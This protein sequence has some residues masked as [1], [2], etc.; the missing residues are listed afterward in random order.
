MSRSESDGV[1]TGAGKATRSKPI[2]ES[3]RERRLADLDLDEHL[4]DPAIKQRYVSAMFDVVAQRYDRFTRMFSYG[5]DAGWKRR[6][7]E[8]LSGRTDIAVAVDLACGSGDLAFGVA[9][10]VPAARV[11][12]FDVSRPMVRL[13][14]HRDTQRS[15]HVGA[16]DMTSVP[17]GTGAADLVTIG[18]GVRNAP[19]PDAALAEAAR[20]LRPGGTLLVLDFYRPRSRLWR[21]LF[22]G[23]LRLAG[24]A[25]G[26]LWHRVPAV[27]GYIAP[28]VRD[29]LTV[30]DFSDALQTHGF[31]VLH[32]RRKL[33]GGIALHTARRR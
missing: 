19:T 22:L 1:S 20:L 7:L 15:V 28:S 14:A 30:D 33:F 17:V 5:M 10:R 32:V 16:A 21:A 12:A 24:N 2:V 25:V 27:Y 18:Y 11:V 31:D 6:L 9:L 8:P 29:Y 3:A 26:W 23:Y 13:A 4:R